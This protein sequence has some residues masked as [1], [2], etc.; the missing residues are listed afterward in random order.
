MPEVE[1]W[2][3]GRPSF[4]KATADGGRLECRIDKPGGIGKSFDN[5]LNIISKS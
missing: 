5:Q 1:R 3:V 4:A 2:K